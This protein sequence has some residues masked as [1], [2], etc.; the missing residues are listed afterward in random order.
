MYVKFGNVK[1]APN[2]Y[3]TKFFR[4][5]FVSSNVMLGG[6]V[7]YGNTRENFWTFPINQ[8]VHVNKVTFVNHIILVGL[9]VGQVAKG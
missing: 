9:Y 1:Y 7:I 8:G 6:V 5:D 3:F 2:V 4:H